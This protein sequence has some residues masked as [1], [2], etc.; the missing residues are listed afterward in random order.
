[1]KKNEQKKVLEEIKEENSN[2]ETKITNN[3]VKTLRVDT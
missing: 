1:M 3:D 2:S